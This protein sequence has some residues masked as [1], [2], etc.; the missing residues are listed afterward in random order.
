MLKTTFVKL[1]VLVP[2]LRTETE[3]K[4]PSRLGF[5]EDGVYDPSDYRTFYHLLTN[6]NNRNIE[7]LFDQCLMA[8]IM[9]KFLLVSEKF[10][11]NEAGI[12]F[13][14]SSEDLIFTGGILFHHLLNVDANNGTVLEL[15]VCV[16]LLEQYIQ[17]M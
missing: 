17:R 3:T 1:K 2:K 4:H 15:E 14:P 8:V 11:I 6:K 12:P 13:T 9:L 10:F 5:N 7:N 16:L